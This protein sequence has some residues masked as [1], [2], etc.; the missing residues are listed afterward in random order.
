MS[1]YKLNLQRR[2]EPGADYGTGDVNPG[3]TPI[4]KKVVNKGAGFGEV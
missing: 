4:A 2:L 1:N 3:P